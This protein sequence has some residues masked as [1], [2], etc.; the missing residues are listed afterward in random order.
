VLGG[1]AGA[2]ALLDEELVSPS[3]GRKIHRLV[4]RRVAR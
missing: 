2:T 3:S 4:A 1:L